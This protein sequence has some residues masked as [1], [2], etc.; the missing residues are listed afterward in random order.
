VE[1]KVKMLVYLIDSE[2]QKVLLGLKKV[3]FGAG[4]WNAFG[5][6]VDQS[7]SIEEATVRELKEESGLTG[8]TDDL[9][10]L[11][12][13]LFHYLGLETS[14]VHIFT[15]HKWLG[16]PVETEEMRPQW[17][18]FDNLPNDSMWASDKPW[19]PK[20]LNEEAFSGEF[21]FD[22]NKRFVKYKLNN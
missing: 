21:W 14:E 9:V 7:E 5:G 19:L 3:R 10:K 12:V 4:K 17:F 22:E 6:K 1:K 16:E 2:N 13:N 15:L 8:K 11:G 20:L 18:S